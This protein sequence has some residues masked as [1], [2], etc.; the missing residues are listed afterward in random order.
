M[1]CLV[2]S[3]THGSLAAV[4]RAMSM[5]P[6]CEVV[7]FLGDGI[8][9]I[10]AVALTRSDIAFIAVRGNCDSTEYF[11]DTALKK[12]EKINILGH[13]ILLTHGDLFSAK[14][15]LGGLK[16]LAKS[17]GVDIVLFGHTHTPCEIYVSD[18]EHPFYLFNPGSASGS[19]AT[20]GVINLCENT[21][22]LLSHG[23]INPYFRWK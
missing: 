16:S 12:V 15:G 10:E 1:K 20:F 11:R 6:D 18:S 14:S 9:D 2:F 19:S 3:D 13:K 8:R 7:F 21:P 23:E 22:P 4:R 17:E 5:H